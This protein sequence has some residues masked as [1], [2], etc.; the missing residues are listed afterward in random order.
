MDM[1]KLRFTVLQQEILRFL[2]IKVG[3]SFN[4]RRIA[5]QLKVSPTAVSNSLKGLERA[6]IITVSKDKESR[7]LSIELNRE[8][9]N[10]F[11]LKRSENLRM[12]YES[13]L[14]EYLT[15]RIPAATIILFGS[16]SFGEDTVN[17]DLD[18]AI[19]GSKEKEINL[20]KFG[21]MLEREISLH[22]Y[23]SLKEIDKNMRENILN[24]IVLKGSV[25]L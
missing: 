22:F 5:K 19:I 11:F 6:G 15:Q 4:E 8:N 20:E 13:G 17:S 10:V 3:M 23:K 25:E 1:Y 24:G 21:R 12:I 14:A 18:I 2:F 9:P 7:R 16:F